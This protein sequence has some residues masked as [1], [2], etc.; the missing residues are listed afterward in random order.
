MP[1]YGLPSLLSFNYTPS[2]TS[3][4]PYSAPFPPDNI[5][6]CDEWLA[7]TDKS[8]K[9]KDI[10]TTQ[11]ETTPDDFLYA[12]KT[13]NWENFE[14]NS[15]TDWLRKKKHRNVLDYFALAK[16][17]EFLQTGDH[18][19]WEE[20]SRSAIIGNAYDSLA[21][22][23]TTLTKKAKGDFLTNRYAF[24]TVKLLYYRKL[25][26][27][28]TSTD[29]ELIKFYDAHLKDKQTIVADWSLLYYALSQPDIITRNYYLIQVFDRTEEKKDYS[30]QWF[31]AEAINQLSDS[32]TN[33]KDL[34]L[35]RSIKAMMNPGRGLNDLQYIIS[36]DADS[37]YI[38]LLVTREINKL[39]DWI[40]SP[41]ILGFTSSLQETFFEKEKYEKDVDY[42]QP[43]TNFIFYA[44]KNLN[45]DRAYL[46]EVNDY[47]N[48]V[49]NKLGNK[50]FVTLA[51]AHLANMQGRHDRATQLLQG[52]ANSNDKNIARQANIEQLL[53]LA[54]SN[55]IKSTGTKDKIATLVA[56]MQAAGDSLKNDQY[57]WQNESSIDIEQRDDLSEI[58]GL[59]RK[60]YEREGDTLT[61]GLLDYKSH[62]QTNEYGYTCK[63]SICYGV[64]SYWDKYGSA[65][66]I[67]AVLALKHKTNKTRFEQMLS[68]GVWGADDMYRDMKGTMY[69]RQQKYVEALRVFET[70]KEN[71]WQ[72]NYEYANYLPKSSLTS[73]GTLLPVKTGTGKT[74]TV[75]SKKL[76]IKEL[77]DL[78]KQLALAKTDKEKSRLYFMLGNAQYNMSYYGKGWMAYAYGKSGGD[79]Y[80]ASDNYNWVYYSLHNSPNN[81]IENYYG[82][83]SAVKMYQTALM[84]AK[85]DKE[86][87]TQCLI[88]LALCERIHRPY[89][90]KRNNW[91]VGI[92]NYNS[93]EKP[94]VSNY[95]KKLLKQYSNT[96]TFTL[97][98]TTCP[99]I[100]DFVNNNK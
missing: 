20:S 34:V 79:S 65:D 39:E 83:E 15:F 37:K 36:K 61:A 40:W 81:H 13:N 48:A 62:L 19:G 8:V 47:L 80:G 87:S 67:D 92:Y 43:D 58:F 1:A 94:F 3:Y 91:V 49:A 55:D 72:T 78:Q 26:T 97:S 22:I 75:S 45:K 71:F 29:P 23:A 95:M 6:N 99:D 66:N 18:S 27:G 10:Y 60:R 70:M 88:M 74:Y 93:E 63:D 51:L 31:N 84:H 86:L 12:Y 57:Y 7:Y 52:I 76:L 24:Q 100:Q 42:N 35:I 11:Y 2:Y 68:P 96:N 14:G 82:L 17:I 50:E 41:E 38:P 56:N 21:R 69:I 4:N 5:R 33:V 25:Y 16:Q 28:D 98:I 30:Y 53:A 73:A 90:D 46:N 89:E 77:V 64:L 54:N 44:D 59:L 32:L 85:A 9:A